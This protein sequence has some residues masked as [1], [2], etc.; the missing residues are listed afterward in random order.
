MKKIIKDTLILTIITVIAGLCLGYVYDITKE[1]IEH[2]REQ[3]KQDAYRAVFADA[4]SF[5]EGDASHVANADA[6]LDE[7]GAVG[8]AIDEALVAKD[9]SG[10]P[11]G[12]VMTVTESEGYGGDITIAMGVKNDGTLNGIEILDISETAGLGMKATTP[13]FKG[14][15]S[16]KK[17][18][19][20]TYTKTGAVNEYEIDAISG[21]TITTKA[22][23]K[24]V[25]AGLYYANTVQGGAE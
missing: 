23:V 14:Q 10:N 25:N 5:E 19:Q 13:E 8:V 6:L 18:A 12:L 15:F 20:F 22:V 4:Q 7:V 1:P 3:A 21:A 17:V 9:A 16:D 11:I 2:S 24:A